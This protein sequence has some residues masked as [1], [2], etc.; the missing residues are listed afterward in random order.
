MKKTTLLLIPALLSANAF[1]GF[2]GGMT[3]ENSKSVPHTTISEFRAQTDITQSDGLFDM[4][5]TGVMADEMEFVFQGN[6]VNQVDSDTYT[7][8]DSTDT[9]LIDLD[10]AL[11]KGRQ[12]SPN[13]R[14]ILYGEAD[15]E[16][17]G[18]YFDVDRLEL[19]Q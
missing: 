3:H 9:I 13:D 6:I 16:E 7:F 11:F 8:R 1:A 14:V 4:F 12:V 10:D 15:Y 2:T 17:V 5:I 18:L 19:I